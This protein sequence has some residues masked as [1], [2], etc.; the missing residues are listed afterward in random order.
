M[1]KS[2]RAFGLAVPSTL[3]G[4]TDQAGSG[5]FRPRRF[6]PQQLPTRAIRSPARH[7]LD[8]EWALFDDSRHTVFDRSSAINSPPDRSTAKPTGLPRA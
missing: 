7:L 4:R 8:A 6:C 1:L 3:I 2:A 5:P